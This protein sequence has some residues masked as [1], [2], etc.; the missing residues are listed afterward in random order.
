MAGLVPAIHVLIHHE[1]AKEDEE[2]E[3]II[4]VPFSIFVPSWFVLLERRG[5]PAQ[6]RA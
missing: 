3:A 4:F 2:H 5:C 1:G 6:G